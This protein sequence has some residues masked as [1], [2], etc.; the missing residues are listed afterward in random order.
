MRLAA[1]RKEMNDLPNQTVGDAQTWRGDANVL[2]TRHLYVSISAYMLIGISFW[3]WC[4]EYVH[5][6]L[7]YRCALCIIMKQVREVEIII[8]ISMNCSDKKM[9]ASCLA[10]FCRYAI[11]SNITSYEMH[12]NIHKITNYGIC[13]N[14]SECFCLVQHTRIFNFII[15]YS[16]SSFTTLFLLY[17]QNNNNKNSEASLLGK[18]DRTTMNEVNRTVTST[19][20]NY[21][22]QSFSYGRYQI[23]LLC[24]FYFTYLSEKRES[25]R[26]ADAGYISDANIIFECRMYEK[27]WAKY[28]TSIII[29]ENALKLT[30]NRV[31]QK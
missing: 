28:H 18:E 21:T 3:F 27:C 22:T 29:N 1:N 17:T 9:V 11:R 31:E 24:L 10:S 19:S 4:S 26:Y 7:K 15:T 23:H 25:L 8:K 12:L 20:N 13:S 14:R 16:L 6:H 5:G 2:N 30:V